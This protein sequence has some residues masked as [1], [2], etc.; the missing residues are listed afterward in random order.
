VTAQKEE[1]SEMINEEKLQRLRHASPATTHRYVHLFQD[2]Q[3]AAAEKVGAA[4]AAAEKV[5][6]AIAA[7]GKDAEGVDGVVERFPGGRH[8]RH[9]R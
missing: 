8:G 4:I 6:A 7:A 3:R 9:G 2:P 5:G 1:K